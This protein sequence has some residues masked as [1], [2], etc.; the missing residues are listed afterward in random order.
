MEVVNK[1]EQGINELVNKQ[2]TNIL[3]IFMMSY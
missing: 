1:Y 3:I 2:L